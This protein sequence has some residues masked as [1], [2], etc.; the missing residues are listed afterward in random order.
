MGLTGDRQATEHFAE[1]LLHISHEIE[2]DTG[3]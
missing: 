1:R 2:E 3:G